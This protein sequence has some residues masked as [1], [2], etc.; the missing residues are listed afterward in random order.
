MKFYGES[1]IVRTDATGRPTSLL[2]RGRLY[3]IQEIEEVWCWVGKW[4]TT[5][6]LRGHKRTYSRVSCLSVNDVPLSLE[7]YREHG[8]WMLSRLLD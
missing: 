2:W 1:I 8:R 3:R 5:P 7:I 6:D 4:W